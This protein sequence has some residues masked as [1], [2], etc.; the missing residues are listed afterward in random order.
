M[1][2]NSIYKQRN[3]HFP[4][5][6]QNCIVHNKYDNSILVKTESPFLGFPRFTKKCHYSAYTEPIL[7]KFVSAESY[8]TCTQ[9]PRVN[10]SKL[11][12]YMG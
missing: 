4:D 11:S 1:I 8:D 12:Q 3:N 6:G 2:Q 7:I 5:R 10:D 9:S